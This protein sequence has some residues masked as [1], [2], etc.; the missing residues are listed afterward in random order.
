[1]TTD[2]IV[3]ELE[4][5]HLPFFR[6]NTED[7]PKYLV[8]HDACRGAQGFELGV[9]DQTINLGRI[10]AAYYRRP[11]LPTPSPNVPGDSDRSYCEAEWL[12]ILKAIYALLGN[13]WLNSPS[14]IDAAE[15][16]P[17]Q[18]ARATGLGFRI[19]KTQITNDAGTA[20]ALLAEGPIIAK[21]IRTALIGAPDDERVIF[22]N[23]V[24]SADRLEHDAVQVAP[25]IFQQHIPKVLDLRVTVV[26][27][28]V[29]AVA[30]HSQDE[31]ETRVDWRQ[32]SSISLEHTVFDLPDA[33]R[34]QCADL[35]A[36]LGLRFGA[37]DLVKDSAG[38]FWFLEI[39]P[40]GQWAWIEN[41]TGLPIAS[42]IVDE[43]EAISKS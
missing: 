22:T 29:F 41:R 7:L 14:A 12:C 6:L 35:V 16:K 38:N 32:G 31:E 36:Q 24:T 15:N 27:R 9:A 23:L 28:K 33:L 11:G 19:P 13:K 26:G 39:N 34:V 3:L 8:R 20:V 21:P 18:L 40:N 1:M 17:L 30:I 25:V 2:F 42:A 10:G 4:R 37:I 5:R 43:L